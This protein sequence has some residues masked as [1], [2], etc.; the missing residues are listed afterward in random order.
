MA[1]FVLDASV[2]VSWCFPGDPGEDTPYS[3]RILAL[4]ANHDAVVPAIWAYEIANSIF[5]SCK[6]RSRINEAQIEEYLQLL[7]AL[8]I[9]Q[10]T[11]GLWSNVQLESRARK[12]DLSPYDAAYLD[13]AK[14]LS[15]P[16]A[17]RDS[18]LITAAESEGIELLSR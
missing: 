12:W 15:L 3:R 16:L 4:L 7:N 5:V 6:R 2:A 10:E 11:S 18:A 8:P 13:L 17:T 1:A 9:R 14:R